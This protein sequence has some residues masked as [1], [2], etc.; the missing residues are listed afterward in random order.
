M[1][2]T[3]FVRRSMAPLSPQLLRYW[4]GRDVLL[5]GLRNVHIPRAVAPM[6]HCMTRLTILGADHNA[7]FYN[8]SRVLFPNV[9]EVRMV[10]PSCFEWQEYSLGPRATWAFSKETSAAFWHKCEVRTSLAWGASVQRDAF[11]EAE[12]VR[13]TRGTAAWRE[14]V[15]LGP[16][17]GW[18]DREWYEDRLNDLFAD[19]AAGEIA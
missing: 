9:T 5:C 17:L 19:A 1:G 16:E 14:V 10:R 18:Q 12:V 13:E 7:M 2:R 6:W 3:E 4:R 11:S 8:A 15:H